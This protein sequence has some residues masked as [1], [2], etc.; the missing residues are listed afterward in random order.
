MRRDIRGLCNVAPTEDLGYRG[1]PFRWHEE[2]HAHLCAELNVYFARLCNLTRDELRC[3][4][5]PKDVYGDNFPYETFR[6]LEEW[7]E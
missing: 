6:V 4:L 7:D 3:I 2:R 1:E 5:D